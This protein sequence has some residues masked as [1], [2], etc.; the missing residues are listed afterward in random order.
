MPLT[1]NYPAVS[2]YIWVRICSLCVFTESRY[3]SGSLGNP[4]VSVL[5]FL[6]Q[7]L[8][9]WAFIMYCCG[10]VCT[11][12]CLLAGVW[13]LRSEPA[14]WPHFPL[15]VLSVSCWHWAQL[16]WLCTADM[17]LGWGAHLCP[18]IQ[19]PRR[20]PVWAKS[21]NPCSTG[22]IH[23]I[24]SMLENHHSSG[25]FPLS[26]HFYLFYS[27]LFPHLQPVCVFLT[28]MSVLS[29]HSAVMSMP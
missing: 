7:T 25:L 28:S 3:Y 8:L 26:S 15:W 13:R 12:L 10:C 20:E 24:K 17:G 1:S 29:C 4:C 16:D 21:A 2:V 22:P 19:T 27:I 23:S 18:L 5:L 6:N 11:V 14:G 9:P